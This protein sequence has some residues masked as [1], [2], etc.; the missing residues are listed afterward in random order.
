MFIKCAMM[1]ARVNGKITAEEVRVVDED[2]NNLGIL[3]PKQALDLARSRAK[4]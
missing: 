3:T 1:Y 4:T 2:G